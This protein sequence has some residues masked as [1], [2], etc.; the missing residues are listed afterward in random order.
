MRNKR[1]KEQ[2]AQR[3]VH[4]GWLLWDKPEKHLPGLRRGDLGGSDGTIR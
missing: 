2:I 4:L 3:S 1:I